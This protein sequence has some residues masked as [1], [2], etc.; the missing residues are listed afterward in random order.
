MEFRAAFLNCK[1][2]FE[3]G[4]HA[5]HSLKTDAA[6]QEKVRGLASALR[7][8][9]WPD[10]PDL[11][12]FCE[13]GAEGLAWDVVSAVAPGKYSLLW[14]EP[15]AP[16]NPLKPYT[17]L[18]L[19]YDTRVFE[20]EE[21][22]AGELTPGE[23]HRYHWLAVRVRLRLAG[24]DVRTFW[25]VI[26]HWPSDFGSGATRGS[27][28]RAMVSKMLSEFMARRLAKGYPAVLMMGDFNCEPF[29]APMT[30]ELLSGERIVSVR[31]Q[32]RVLNPRTGLLHL[33]NPM[34]RALGESIPVEQLLTGTVPHRP[35]GTYVSLTAKG[36]AAAVWRCWDHVL[37]NRELLMGDPAAIIEDSLVISPTRPGASDHCA[38]GV[39][40]IYNVRG[41]T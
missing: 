38:V 15:P 28:P 31:E 36:A 16:S 5:D 21:Q 8:A 40:F 39:K 19:G 13:I 22:A 24:P 4:Q 2:L 35:P 25:T 41:R 26:N 34:W 18:T 12:G 29:D 11:I 10:L 33:Y 3:V 1:L 37:V 9:F 20:I 30:G 7:R 6:L 14:Q 32:R 23:D 27:W 17:G